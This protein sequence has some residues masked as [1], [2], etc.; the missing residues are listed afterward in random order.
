M[1]KNNK[2]IMTN[3]LDNRL[4]ENYVAGFVHGDGDFS[5]G[6]N[7]RKSKVR[8][9]YGAEK[10]SNKLKLILVPT[11]TLTQKKSNIL[12]MERIFKK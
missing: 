8:T 4:R 3:V 6:L 11:F 10:Q 12:L 2:K 9:P 7:I 1:L 5:I